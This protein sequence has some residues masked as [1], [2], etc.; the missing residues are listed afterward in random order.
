MFNVPN[1]MSKPELMSDV[2]NPM[3]NL[4]TETDVQTYPC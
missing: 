1:L 2:P 4:K 3:S